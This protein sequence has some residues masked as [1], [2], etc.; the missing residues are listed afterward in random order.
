MSEKHVK[1]LLMEH[2]MNP[3]NV[4]EMA[5]ASG[6]GDVGNPMCGDIVRLYVKI[7]GDKIEKATF[8]TFGC[9]A[10]IATSSLLTEMLPGKSVNDAL[11]I[12]E[13]DM[14][15]RLGDLPPLKR[16]CGKLAE[17]AL[18]SALGDYFL[19]TKGD[20]KLL[21]RVAE[22]IQDPREWDPGIPSEDSSVA[23]PL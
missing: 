21:D 17:L 20:Q 19:K 14:L 3:R 5:D 10:A 7:K 4:G 15:D 1:D 6:V 9:R 18:Q 13:K 8:K 2:F 11:K 16:H 12:T 22:R 23:G